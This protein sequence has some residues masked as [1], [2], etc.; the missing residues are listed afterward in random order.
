MNDAD[1]KAYS[2]KIFSD[3]LNGRPLIENNSVWRR[4]PVVYTDRWNAGKVVLIGDALRS[5]HYSIGSGTRL[6]MD[7]AIA[8][9]GAIADSGS[10]P[11]AVELYE[12]RRRP[13]V[14]RFREAA[15]RSYEWYEQL[16]AKM[17]LAPMD[18]VYDFM[19]RTGRV[20]DARLRRE[21]PRFMEGYE[22]ARAV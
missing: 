7:D 6:A 15:R 8:L 10:V 19:R 5:A 11:E 20:D 22:S 2:E 14:V 4:F 17:Q 3:E 21:S 16:P 9:S 13:P 12:Q 1:R 18:L